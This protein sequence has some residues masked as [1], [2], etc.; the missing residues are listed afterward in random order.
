[1]GTP[2][3]ITAI[4]GAPLCGGA[5]HLDALLEWQAALKAES[6]ARDDRSGRHNGFVEWRD[7]VAPNAERHS[8][9]IMA[10][11]R[12][13]PPPPLGVLPIPI[14]RGRV[15]PWPVAK[16]SSPILSRGHE[17]VDRMV[18]R[19]CVS[20]MGHLLAPGGRQSIHHGTGPTKAYYRPVR[21]LRVERV[22]WF[23]VGYG[24]RR[25]GSDENRRRRSAAGEMR[26]ALKGIAAIGAKRDAGYGRVAE[27]I[28]EEAEADWSW[29]APCDGG[30]AL[31]RPL[32]VEAVPEDAC[33]CR[34][35]FCAVCPPY[36]HPERYT[37]AMEPC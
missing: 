31:M 29:F 24:F 3:K 30:Q 5:P 7:A 16:C 32:P 10:P 17:C 13:M 23:C 18:K 35:A 8:G 9:F 19:I 37:E 36:W 12:G 11:Q 22:V 2:L 14:E 26:K 28:V 1:M 34:P 20:E 27:W 4:M 25:G 6:F 15:G 21:V 33:Y